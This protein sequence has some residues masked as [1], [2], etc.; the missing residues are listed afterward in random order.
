MKPHNPPKPSTVISPTPQ[1]VLLKILEQHVA[2]QRLFGAAPEGAVAPLVR[3]VADNPAQRTPVEALPDGSVVF[4]WEWV[5]A[6]RRAELTELVVSMLPELAQANETVVEAYVIDAALRR[7]YHGR[8]A[9]LRCLARAQEI[10]DE[11]PP[12]QRRDYHDT[13]LVTYATKLFDKNRRTVLHYTALLSTPHEIQDALDSGQLDLKAVKAIAKLADQAKDEI[14]EAIRQG[15]KARD[16]VRQY[17]GPRSGRHK[18]ILSARNAALK[19][20]ERIL[21]DLGGRV[22]QITWVTR[23]QFQTLS[24]ARRIDLA[25]AQLGQGRRQ[26]GMER[27]P[28]GAEVGTGRSSHGRVASWTAYRAWAG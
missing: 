1:R 3:A 21:A 11:L 26:D 28:A 10:G 20:L 23:P 19:G 24:E 27:Q 13:D 8:M 25:S 14:A 7:G 18:G 22:E 5:E 6:A 15:A 9:K 12:D 16:V 4:G 17:I 2:Y